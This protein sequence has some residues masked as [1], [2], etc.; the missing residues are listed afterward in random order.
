[1]PGPVLEIL[2]GWRHCPLSPD[3]RSLGPVAKLHSIRKLRRIWQGR[4]AF[5]REVVLAVSFG[6]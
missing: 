5:H 1:M 3:E 2:Q 6:R 4:G